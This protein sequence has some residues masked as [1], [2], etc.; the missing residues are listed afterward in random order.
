MEASIR[1]AGILIGMRDPTTVRVTHDTRDGL[2]D[3]ANADGVTLNEEVNRLVR[4]E[5]QRRI[6][7]ALA[8]LEL[9]EED[10]L[11]LEAGADVVR[12]D[13]GR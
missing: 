10:S 7:H 13:E 9:D 5:R 12:H 2:R 6:G 4:A 8:A 3:L 11:W 1:T